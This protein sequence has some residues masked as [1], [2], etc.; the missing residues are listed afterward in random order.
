[1]CGDVLSYNANKEK[2]TTKVFKKTSGGRKQL[3]FMQKTEKG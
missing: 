1:M 2:P 3:C